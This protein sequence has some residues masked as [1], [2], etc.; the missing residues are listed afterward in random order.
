MLD[1]SL[2]VVETMTNSEEAMLYLYQEGR[3]MQYVRILGFV[4]CEI[5][6]N[7]QTV[8]SSLTP[9]RMTALEGQESVLFVPLV[10][11]GRATGLIKAVNSRDDTNRHYVAYNEDNVREVSIL[12]EKIAEAYSS[13]LQD[14]ATDL[15][16]LRTGIRQAAST[17]NAIT[18]ISTIRQA[19]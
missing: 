5:D 16:I 15:E 13:H 10:S 7:M 8:L 4:D 12:A 14:S 17:M 6:E 2:D 1:L 9:K 19:V 18:L 3:L 11:F